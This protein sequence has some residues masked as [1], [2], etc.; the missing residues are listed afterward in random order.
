M[1]TDG[2][3]GI[4]ENRKGYTPRN[5]HGLPSMMR[6]KMTREKV[7]ENRKKS[8]RTPNMYTIPMYRILGKK[9]CS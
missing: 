4:E 2:C 7:R 8:Q 1:F 3:L 9:R 5:S 6:D